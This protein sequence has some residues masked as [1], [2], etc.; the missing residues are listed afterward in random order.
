M[1]DTRA[2]EPLAPA[3]APADRSAR[4][5]LLRR[6]RELALVPALLVLLVLGAVVND[7]FL[8]ER[9]LISIL[10]ASAALAMV[11]LAESLILITGKI[12]LSLESVVG[13]AP[14][15]GALLVLPSAESGWGTEWPTGLALV[16]VLVV[17]AVIGAF[18]GV[19][20]VKFKLNAFIVTLAMLIVLR[21]L[22]VGATKG[23]TLFGMP[24]AF[25][26]LATSTVLRVPLSVWLA[27]VAFAV[28]GFL[29]KYH[30]VGRALYAIGG[31]AEAARAAGIRVDRMLL[32]VSVVAG[33]LAS[34]GGIMQT[35]YV[36]A[37]SANQGNNMIFTVMAAAVIGGISLDGGKGT[38][39]GA[40]TGV[41]LLGVVQNL[42][43][44][45][46]V[47]S[48]WIQAIYGGI[49]LVALMIARVTTGR[50]Q[51]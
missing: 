11:V 31:N 19:L 21:G 18:N 40:L 5:V 17:G 28:A 32:G 29:L 51:D 41:L 9:N 25:F 13:I 14:A 50:A 22:L 4:T 43:T 38:M 26:Q 44:L 20:V 1:A 48:F 3:R 45:A 12:D 24:D 47:P 39:F 27:A 10:G 34:V 33:V 2:A 30:R 23:K 36:G 37:I 42:L 16:A 7:S 8:T 6:A 15:I 35:G 46:Q 49:I